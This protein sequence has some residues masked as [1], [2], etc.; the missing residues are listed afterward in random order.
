MRCGN[1][2]DYGEK[3][4]AALRLPSSVWHF[5]VPVITG[6][7][8]FSFRHT[9]RSLFRYMF[10]PS[11]SLSLFLPSLSFFLSFSLL[12]SIPTF[13]PFLFN[14]FYSFSFS[15]SHPRLLPSPHLVFSLFFSLAG[16]WSLNEQH[17]ASVRGFENICLFHWS[18]H[19][20]KSFF[21]PFPSGSS[22]PRARTSAFAS[23]TFGM[24]SD[25]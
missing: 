25:R 24:R 4:L 7:P 11:L 22:I 2:R 1:K 23:Y 17:S 10:Y 15:F 19:N 6:R 21:L 20:M 18:E 12:L 14:S 16:L 9:S 8:L 3:V 5:A 13:F